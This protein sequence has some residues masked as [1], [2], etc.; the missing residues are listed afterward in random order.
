MAELVLN[1]FNLVRERWVPIA[2]R[3]KASLLELFQDESLPGIGGNPIEKISLLK[4]A[5]AIAQAA[6]TPKN[7]A[8]WLSV[9]AAGLAERSAQYLVAHEDEFWLHGDRPFLQ[10][11]AIRAARKISAGAVQPWIANGNT[12]IR[13]QSQVEPHYVDGDL[14]LIVITTANF[15]LGGK[16]TDND[17][18]LSPGYMDKSATGKSGP[19][20]GY[21]GYLHNFL[22]GDTVRDSV[23]LNLL[24]FDDL[25]G[26]GYFSEGLG[27]PVWEHMPAGEDDPIARKARE[28]YLGR[29]VPLSRFVLLAEDGMHYSEG[30]AYP[31]H[32]DGAQDVSVAVSTDAEK[33]AL[34]TNPDKRPWRQLPALLAFFDA[35]SQ[36]GYDC[37]LLR[38]A[39]P[40]ASSVGIDFSLWSGGLKVSNNAGEQYVSG[41]DDFV[42]SEVSLRASFIGEAWFRRL[43]LEMEVLSELGN[44][45]FGSVASYFKEL[46]ADGKG[47]AAKASES[48]WADCESAFQDLVE[49]CGSSDD[50]ACAEIRARL[51]RYAETRYDRACP[52]ENARQIESWAGHRVS[53]WRYL[54][55]SEAAA[56]VPRKP[57]AGKKKKA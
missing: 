36:D 19:S 41:G 17:I 33:K 13:L 39:I 53:T 27:H 26:M 52:R 57:G 43:K 1:R 11:P 34:W 20:L 54:H 5:I 30:I 46:K 21:L 28:S 29:L 38:R 18:V 50:T 44:A 56:A 12:T 48:F 32:K 2:G 9:G 10:M 24:T 15:A 22:I 3:G 35:N 4:L 51:A 42:E 8:D 25:S 23:W 7:E 14:A 55:A 6:Y 45:V 37:R 16:K 40:R 47:A 31:G 49:A